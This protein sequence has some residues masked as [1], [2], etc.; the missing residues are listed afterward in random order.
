VRLRATVRWRG[1]GGLR[2]R[3]ERPL[4]LEAALRAGADDV[5]REVSAASAQ[6]RAPGSAPSMPI[7][8]VRGA[9]ALSWRIV[10]RD[11][12]FAEFGSRQRPARPTLVPALITQAD[13]ISSRIALS[14]RHLLRTGTR[15]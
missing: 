1:P 13:R 14:L 9:D 10:S 3:L 2:K 11:G 12:W 15:G 5:R 4:A 8:I 7:E 6:M